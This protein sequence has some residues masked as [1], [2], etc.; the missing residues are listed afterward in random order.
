M[1]EVT[2]RPRDTTRPT[3][4]YLKVSELYRR[5]AAAAI[6]LDSPA[7]LN[8]IADY[9]LRVAR[10][11]YSAGA[12]PQNCRA[13]LAKAAKYFIGHLAASRE[14]P[15][16]GI[17]N[18]VSYLENMSAACLTGTI[19][20]CVQRLN[21]MRVESILPWQ[22]SVLSL[23]GGVFEGKDRLSAEP[24]LKGAPPEYGPRF[25]ELFLAAMR[26]DHTEFA[27]KLEAYLTQV[28]GPPMDRGAKYDLT[29]KPP[30]YTGKW[31]FFSA[32]L[33]A[34]MHQSPS[35]GRKAMEY[36]PLDLVEVDRTSAQPKGAKPTE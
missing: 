6:K 19:E 31:A 22:A 21:A 8:T 5:A 9:D 17:P 14:H 33:C 23:I 10:A 36:A 26:K 11:L 16:K 2:S 32:A 15:I 24:D 34:V 4:Y 18:M 1:A 28:W 35:L 20:P 3:Q 12:P 27:S 13:E 25:A 30:S 29:S 7:V